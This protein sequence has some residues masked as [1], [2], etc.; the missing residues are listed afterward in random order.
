MEL[1]ECKS[2]C[3]ET[4][5]KIFIGTI[6]KAHYYTS[7]VENFYKVIINLINLCTC[8]KGGNWEF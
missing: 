5:N 1:F 2:I 7:F 8:L 3:I 4:I 6:L